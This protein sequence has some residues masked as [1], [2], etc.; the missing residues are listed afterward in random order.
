[1]KR[2]C[3]NNIFHSISEIGDVRRNFHFFND[4]DDDTLGRTVASVLSILEEYP[5]TQVSVNQLLNII[6]RD[7]NGFNYKSASAVYEPKDLV[8]YAMVGNRFFIPSCSE[9]ESVSTM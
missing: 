8:F 6:F 9:T 2:W 3:N 4:E 5:S 1:M 7:D